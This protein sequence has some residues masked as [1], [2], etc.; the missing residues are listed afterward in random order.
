MSDSCNVE[1]SLLII[2]RFQLETGTKF[3]RIVRGVL[4]DEK[5]DVQGMGVVWAILRPRLWDTCD[6]SW[7]ILK[8]V[9]LPGLSSPS[10]ERARR[11]FHHITEFPNLRIFRGIRQHSVVL[12]KKNYYTLTQLQMDRWR[13]HI[14]KIRLCPNRCLIDIWI[15]FRFR[16]QLVCRLIRRL[17]GTVRLC[18]WKWKKVLY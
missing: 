3:S 8:A 13:F 17:C 1:W 7:T 6:L 10:Q 16:H 15:F 11:L 12:I 18:S 5:R 14:G 2:E 4:G 9:C